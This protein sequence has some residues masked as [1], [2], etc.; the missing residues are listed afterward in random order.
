VANKQ[1][2]GNKELSKA[3][4]LRALRKVIA[5]VPARPCNVTGNVTKEPCNVTG[6]VTK[7]PCNVTGNVTGNVTKECDELREEIEGLCRELEV[8]MGMLDRIRRQSSERVRRFRER[9]K[10]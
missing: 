6:N 1:Q 3:D 7:E 8:V 5:G 10:F 4:Q 2:S 9:R